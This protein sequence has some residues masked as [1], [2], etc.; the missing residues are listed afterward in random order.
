MTVKP[1]IC[2]VEDHFAIRRAI[3]S[4]VARD[5]EI[6]CEVEDG[7]ELIPS[8]QALH[9]DVILLDISLPGRS[10]MQ[11]LPELRSNLPNTVIVMVTNNRASIYREEAFRRGADA[12]VDK[13]DLATELL[14]AIATALELRGME[15]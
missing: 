3:A 13:S 14:P 6:V 10:G 7:N 2:L 5:Y 15:S 11:I 1:R 4:L 9:P 12:F 8:T